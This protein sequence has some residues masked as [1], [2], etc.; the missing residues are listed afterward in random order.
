MTYLI[1]LSDE[2]EKKRG[3]RRAKETERVCLCNYYRVEFLLSSPGE[4]IF[5][6]LVL[7]PLVYGRDNERMGERERFSKSFREM[8]SREK[9]TREER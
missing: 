4:S 3:R 6:S 2:K 8:V 7:S 9:E 1:R 5:K